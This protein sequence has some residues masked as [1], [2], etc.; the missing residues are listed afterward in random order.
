MLLKN[1]K[2]ISIKKIKKDKPFY[3]F[4]KHSEERIPL[5]RSLNKARTQSKLPTRN[6]SVVWPARRLTTLKLRQLKFSLKINLPAPRF[7]SFTRD[8]QFVYKMNMVES[9]EVR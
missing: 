6:F 3:L 5:R 4:K 1:S 2:N 9:H 8:T 7:T